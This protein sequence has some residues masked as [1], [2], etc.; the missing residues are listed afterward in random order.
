MTSQVTK[1]VVFSALLA[2][3]TNM[4]STGK[5]VMYHAISLMKIWEMYKND[6]TVINCL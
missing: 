1:N 3:D 5:N 4:L 2:D 6:Y